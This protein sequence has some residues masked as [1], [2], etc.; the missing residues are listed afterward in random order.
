MDCRRFQSA[1]LLECYLL[2]KA[3]I[4][5]YD[6]T[7]PITTN[8]HGVPN[9]DIDYFKW[10]KHQDVIS[11]DSYPQYD[12]PAHETAF[13]FDLMRGLGA[14]KPFMLMES[15]PGQVNW[16]AYSPLKR[17][18]QMFTQSLQAIA[19]GADT[20]QYFQLKQ[21]IG[22]QEKFHGVVIAHSQ[23]TDTRVFKEI[24]RL[25]QT[26][27][28]LGTTFKDSRVQAKVAVLFDWENMWALQ[29]IAGIRQDI[30]YV[31]IVQ[32][33]YRHF[34]EQNITVD[35]IGN[36]NDF[37]AY[38]LV[39]APVLYMVSP[40]LKQKLSDYVAKGGNLVT[41][42]LSGLVDQNDNVY[43]GGY[44]GALR[45]LT[46]IWVEETDV[47][48]PK[49]TIWVD[50]QGQKYP[51]E[52]LCDL[53]HPKETEVLATYASE[54]YAGMAATTKNNFGKGKVWY[55]AS[56]FADEMLAKLVTS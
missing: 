49:Q 28:R 56:Q 40:Q 35:V 24:Q 18:G 42:Y 21:S 41:T 22:A 17:P 48:V 50:Y 5:K 14:G 30:D 34:Y 38:D 7:T 20:V 11:Y 37:S 46:G 27:A 8:F 3:E 6:T 36:T 26:L 19:H 31:K 1:S 2:E 15:T 44:P 23:R 29:Y 45:E 4:E 39:V 16:Q 12:T 9:N 55:F 13:W 33:Y 54:F 53:V 10:A 32:T 25:G 52:L 51:T 43:L 47:V